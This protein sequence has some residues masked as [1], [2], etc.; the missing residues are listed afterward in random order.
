M[1][2]RTLVYDEDVASSVVLALDHP[3]AAGKLY[4]IS[5]GEFHSLNEI[6]NLMCA[7]LGRPAPR[8]R[9]PLTP[10]RLAVRFLERVSD[11]FGFVPPVR[12]STIDKYTEDITV[13]NQ[14]IC[15]DLGFVPRISLASGWRQ[16]VDEMKLKGEL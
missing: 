15:R 6:V 9:V 11:L 8:I 1:N 2:R 10:V 4:N 14:L 13:S 5:D 12:S 3:R 16:T 7:A